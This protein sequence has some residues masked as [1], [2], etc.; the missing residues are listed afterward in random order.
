MRMPSGLLLSFQA[1]LLLDPA[2]PSD[3]CSPVDE[4]GSL[5]SVLLSGCASPAAKRLSIRLIFGFH[6]LGP[7]VGNQDSVS[8]TG[9]APPNDPNSG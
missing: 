2:P 3:C 5:S 7:E 4:V 9:Y 1:R 8:C 6:V